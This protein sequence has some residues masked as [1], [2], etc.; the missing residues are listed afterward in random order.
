MKTIQKIGFI[1]TEPKHFFFYDNVIKKLADHEYEFVL[2][3]YREEAFE[4]VMSAASKR[5][6]NYKV[7]SEVKGNKQKYKVIVSVLGGYKGGVERLQIGWPFNTK[8]LPGKFIN[9]YGWPKGCFKSVL[10][11]VYSNTVGRILELSNLSKIM[12]YKYNRDFVKKRSRKNFLKIPMP[13]ANDIGEIRVLAESSYD[14]IRE[15]HPTSPSA[16]VYD[17]FFCISEMQKGFIDKNVGKPTFLVGYTRYENLP[18]KKDAINILINEF[19]LD[20]RKKIIVWVPSSDTKNYLSKWVDPMIELLDGYNIICRP[21]PDSWNA[22]RPVYEKE[23]WKKMINKGIFIDKCAHRNLGLLYQAAD[24]VFCDT[25]APVYSA[26]YFN[27]DI[28]ILNKVIEEGSA[29]R[30]KEKRVL[31]REEIN[32][33]IIKVDR[34]SIDDS[35][36]K[37]LLSNV[38]LWRTQRENRDLLRKRIFGDH[39]VGEGSAIAAQKLQELLYSK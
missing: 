7:T 38:N 14:E 34:E 15:D 35:K 5:G 39:S 28:I 20:L 16:E 1:I 11:Y 6:I 26:L 4:Q 13:I 36:L 2:N 17:Y 27:K 24:Y 33:T 25:G 31:F 22:N 37:A 29:K 19:G 32:S 21:H 23:I 18:K 8:Q 10:L 3:D 9:K 12:E 30:K